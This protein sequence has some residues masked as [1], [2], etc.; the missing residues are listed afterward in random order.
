[1]LALSMLPA[2]HVHDSVSGETVAHRHV[3]DEDSD[4]DDARAHTGS[5]LDHGDHHAAKTLE[6]AFVSEH[7]FD[8]DH[9]VVTVERVVTVPDR[10]F[11][12]RVEATDDVMTHGPPIRV[13][14][15]RAP[16]A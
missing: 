5:S 6:P 15:L 7:Q 14:S 11:I 13:D 1:M 12:G 3:V 4:H 8:L 10:R 2:V 16:P 9:P